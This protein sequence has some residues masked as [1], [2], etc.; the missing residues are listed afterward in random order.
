MIKWLKNKYENY[1]LSK[2]YLS[3]KTMPMYNWVTLFENKDIS[4]ISRTGKICKRLN[5]VCEK[6]QD[7]VIDTFGINE[8]FLQII[9]NKIKIEILYADQIE[10]GDR[11]TGWKI[12]FL[13]LDNKELEGKKTKHDF[14]GNIML[15]NQHIKVDF[16][17]ITIYEYYSLSKTVS[18]KLKHENKVK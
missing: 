4:Q 13:E 12:E 10:T 16:K 6:L 7:E 5:K 15:I 18:N 1:Q 8:D 14:F 2:Y 17:T 9:K 3:I 11:S